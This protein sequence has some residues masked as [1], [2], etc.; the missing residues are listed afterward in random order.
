MSTNTF[1]PAYDAQQDFER[2][3]KQMDRIR[4]VMLMASAANKWMTLGEIEQVTRYPQASISAQ[5]RH[6]RKESFGAYIV[7]KRRREPAYKGIWEYFVK[8]RPQQMNFS[9]E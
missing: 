1:G 5:L 6:L 9:W 7:K 2:L 8:K 4:E 3:T